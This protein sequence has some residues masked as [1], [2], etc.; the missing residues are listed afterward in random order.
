M[1]KTL[2]LEAVATSDA[3]VVHG[4][5]AGQVSYQ[6]GLLV[7]TVSHVDR[8]WM[9]FSLFGRTILSKILSVRSNAAAQVG[10]LLTLSNDNAQGLRIEGQ[11]DLNSDGRVLLDVRWPSELRIQMQRKILRALHGQAGGFSLQVQGIGTIVSILLGL[12]FIAAMLASPGIGKAEAIPAPVLRPLAA[13]THI[14]KADTQMSS[15]LLAQRAIDQGEART[16][17]LLDAIAQA[18]KIV[19]RPAPVGGKSLLIWSDVLCPHC[20]DLEQNVVANLPED[21]GVTIIPVSFKDGSRPLASYVVCGSDA[22]DKSTRWSGLMLLTPVAHIE[23]QC[24]AGPGIIDANTLLFVRAGL[25]ATPSI[26]TASGDRIFSD[27]PTNL[28]KIVAWV[29]K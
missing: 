15:A 1:E 11:I 18:N 27:D 28:S 20:R 14:Q 25:T 19:L 17:P 4:K 23:R 13:S 6:D 26:M 2:I 10:P 29:K 9:P 21:I 12:Y 3:P 22:E 8:R 5:Y 16:V 24:E 7:L